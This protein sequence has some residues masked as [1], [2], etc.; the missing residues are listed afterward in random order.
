MI[1]NP[2]PPFPEGKG[3]SMTKTRALEG[4]NQAVR[5][6]M[7]AGVELGVMRMWNGKGEWCLCFGGGVMWDEEKGFSW[8]C[9]E[10]DD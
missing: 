1:P 2:L 9:P 3:E 10:E 5:V 7:L 4:L 6:C 8:C